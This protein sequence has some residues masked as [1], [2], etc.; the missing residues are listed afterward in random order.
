MIYLN[1][2]IL[3]EQL[4]NSWNLSK[5]LHSQIDRI[6]INNYEDILSMID[7]KEFNQYKNSLLHHKKIADEEG[8]KVVGIAIDTNCIQ[9]PIYLKNKNFPLTMRK[10]WLMNCIIMDIMNML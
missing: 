4:K 1:Y 2:L 6:D 9:K 10:Q 5:K 3:S 8:R 7:S